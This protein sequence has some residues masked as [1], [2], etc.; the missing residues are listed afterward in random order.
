M[1]NINEMPSGG[2]QVGETVMA[3]IL[4][5]WTYFMLIDIQNC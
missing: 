1:P 5:F 4:L 3:V 2:I